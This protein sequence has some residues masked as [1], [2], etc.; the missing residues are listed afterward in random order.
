MLV[1]RI[2]IYCSVINFCCSLCDMK[3][4]LIIL[5]QHLL[6]DPVNIKHGLAKNYIVCVMH[7]TRSYQYNLF[8]GK[9]RFISSFLNTL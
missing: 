8:D 4:I 9:V 3:K 6:D 1:F 2:N 7:L 5:L